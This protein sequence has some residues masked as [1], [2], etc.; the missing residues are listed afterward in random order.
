MMLSQVA[1]CTLRLVE[2]MNIGDSVDQNV[3]QLTCF[4]L[5]PKEEF[6]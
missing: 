1:S 2:Q 4:D 6:S 3:I 5:D